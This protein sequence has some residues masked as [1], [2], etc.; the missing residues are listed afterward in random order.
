M[1]P[2]YR[3]VPVSRSGSSRLRTALPMNDPEATAVSLFDCDPW[4]LEAAPACGL[5]LRRSMVRQ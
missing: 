2:T 1:S 4:T 3:A 5:I